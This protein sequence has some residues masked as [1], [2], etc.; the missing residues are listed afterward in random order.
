MSLLSQVLCESARS[1]VPRHCSLLSQISVWLQSVAGDALAA[2]WP[3]SEAA[4]SAVWALEVGGV[5]AGQIAV[6][7]GAVWLLYSCVMWC[8]GLRSAAEKKWTKP[9]RHAPPRGGEA[10]AAPPTSKPDPAAS[11]PKDGI[12]R[13][14]AKRLAAAGKR[15]GAGDGPRHPL[16]VATGK[17]HTGTMTAVCVSPCASIIAT[18]SDD[19]V[20]RMSNV[21]ALASGGQRYQ[22]R[23]ADPSLSLPPHTHTHTHTQTHTHIHTTTTTTTHTHVADYVRV[24]TAL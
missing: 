19:G 13:A 5:R 18:A 21:A 10:S 22:V 6:A 7:A 12:T 1:P 17:G 4:A 24:S 20:V 8:T 2:A 23:S 3:A 16:L 11:A 15:R 14:E 9:R